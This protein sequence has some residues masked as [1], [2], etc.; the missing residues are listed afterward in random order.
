M[1]RWLC[2]VVLIGSGLASAQAQNVYAGLGLGLLADSGL[3]VGVQAGGAV[4]ERFGVR[5]VLKSDFDILL[6]SAEG[7]YTPSPAD[8]VWQGYVGGGLTVTWLPLFDGSETYL[9]PLPTL[10]GGYVYRTGGL[11]LFGELRL[12]VFIPFP[13]PELRTGLNVY[14]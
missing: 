6:V 3:S 9:V 12:L 1:K 7:F 14:F 5:G 8:A 10:T 11:G 4:S 2:I 13:A